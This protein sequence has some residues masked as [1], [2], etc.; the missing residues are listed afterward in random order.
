M[1]CII[2]V[3]ILN[4]LYHF[5]QVHDKVKSEDLVFGRIHGRCRIK[6]SSRLTE[7]LNTYGEKTTTE[8]RTTFE[9]P[10]II[11]CG[12]ERGA[13]TSCSVTKPL[14]RSSGASN[15]VKSV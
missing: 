4:E 13:D 3:P 8:H 9:Q 5:T 7:Y 11:D 1:I 10:N 6:F 14:T 15:E 2:N 12:N